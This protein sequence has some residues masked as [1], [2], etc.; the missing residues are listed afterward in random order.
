M[1]MIWSQAI[2]DAVAFA[3]A[4]AGA[5]LGFWFSK[6]HEKRNT[7][8]KRVV[9]LAQL[10]LELIHIQDDVPAYNQDKAATPDPIH[11]VALERLLYGD[12]L[13]F[14]AHGDLIAH[15]IGLQI[16]LNHYNDFLAMRNIAQFSLVILPSGREQL[17]EELAAR[18]REVIARRDDVISRVR[19][20]LPEEK[21]SEPRRARPWTPRVLRDKAV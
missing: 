4:F 17:F 9:L 16:A 10:H 6:R 18:F 20:L 11:I 19:P 12:V 3:A 15:L 21:P 5:Y 2:G 1:D 14:S 8:A 7:E 13:E